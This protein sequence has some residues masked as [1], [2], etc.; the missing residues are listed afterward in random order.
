MCWEKNIPLR[1]I[2]KSYR[3]I[4][5]RIYKS[6]DR[7]SFR[8][9]KRCRSTIDIGAC[10]AVFA[11]TDREVPV[12][13]DTDRTISIWTTVFSPKREMFSRIFKSIGI[14]ARY[15]ID[16]RFIQTFF[17]FWI[18]ML[19]SCNILYKFQCQLITDP[20]SSM[21]TSCIEHRRFLVSSLYILRDFD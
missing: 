3:N 11:P 4:F 17:E 12:E 19:I 1:V 2:V 9:A 7:T 5:M 21:D 8:F 16:R 13:I 14:E 10:V 20:L 18:N 15:H 6:F